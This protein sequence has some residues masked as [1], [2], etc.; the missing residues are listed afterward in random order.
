MEGARRSSKLGGDIEVQD[1]LVLHLIVMFLLRRR[2]GQW[3]IG[4]NEE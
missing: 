3:A 4:N 2:V 1:T